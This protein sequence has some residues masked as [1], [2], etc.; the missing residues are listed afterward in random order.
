MPPKDLDRIPFPA[1]ELL[2]NADYIRYGKKK[3]GY[4][5]TTVMS[6][7]GC[8]YKCEFCSNVV[9]G[10]SYRARSPKNVVD[11]IEAALAAPAPSAAF[12]P[13]GRWHLLMDKILHRI[14][15]A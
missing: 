11:E 7:R 15:H 4:S 8:P 1:R 9:F 5:I 6:T 12:Q 10:N 14:R 13:G 3:Y 2:P